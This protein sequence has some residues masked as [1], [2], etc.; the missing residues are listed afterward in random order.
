MIFLFFPPEGSMK[1]VAVADLHGDADAL[2]RILVK[3]QSWD[4]F[5][6]A[7]DALGVGG[8]NN[9]VVE[10]LSEIENLVAVLGEWDYAVIY[11]K[12]ALVARGS[13]EDV[14]RIRDELRRENTDFLR[15]LPLV[16][17][18]QIDGKQL[19]VVHGTPDEL[20]LQGIGPWT[21]RAAI[22]AYL[23]KTDILI[24]GHTHI[25]HV[26]QWKT[27]RL[28][29]RIYVNPGSP[30]F[31]KNEARKTYAI[32]ETDGAHLSAKIRTV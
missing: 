7:G 10:T 1:I 29:S 12:T 6:F 13:A 24:S 2:D 23:T 22:R 16:G 21:E 8:S 9:E 18:A 4:L 20:L 15:G 14:L 3:E 19:T 30:A 25:P 31:P 28:G 32:L 17:K 5:V 26:F 11:G 27:K